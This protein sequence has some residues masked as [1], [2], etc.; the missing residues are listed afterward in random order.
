LTIFEIIILLRKINIVYAYIQ[1]D[2][3]EKILVT[4]GSWLMAHGSWHVEYFEILT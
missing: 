1:E 3:F 4:H 2:A